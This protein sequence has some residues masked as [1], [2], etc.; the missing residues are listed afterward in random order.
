M[1]AAVLVLR[2]SWCCCTGRRSRWCGR[3]L[4]RDPQLVLVAEDDSFPPAM[5]GVVIGSYDGRRGWIFRLAV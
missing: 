3:K 2:R 5:L 1:A 4:E